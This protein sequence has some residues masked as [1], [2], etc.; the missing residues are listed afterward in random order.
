MSHDLTLIV[1]VRDRT[2]AIPRVIEYYTDLDC[3]KVIVDSS[4]ERY[5][6]LLRIGSFEYH[7]YG[8][9]LYYHKLH[10]ILLDVKTKYVVEVCDDDFI[11]KSAV[12]ECIQFLEEHPEVIGC[13]GICCHIRTVH[14]SGKLMLDNLF[15]HSDEFTSLAMQAYLI[16]T[17]RSR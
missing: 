10:G 15:L 12:P 1:P 11:V 14:P 2:Q 4:P 3:R 6:N 5:T 8:P 17:D 9:V 7:Y 13:D 16:T